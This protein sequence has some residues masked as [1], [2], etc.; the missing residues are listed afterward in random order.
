[1]H[2]VPGHVLHLRRE[3]AQTAPVPP[4][5]LRAVHPAALHHRTGLPPEPDP[6]A[7]GHAH[8]SQHSLPQLPR[9]FRDDGGE[10]EAAAHRPQSHPAA[11][12]F[13]AHAE[14]HC[15]L[16]FQTQ[17]AAIAFLL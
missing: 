17:P 12:F 6:R 9:K 13:E 15:E 3:D 16:L 10:P 2:G 11:G 4:L 5:V 14:V 1:M 8:G 7:P